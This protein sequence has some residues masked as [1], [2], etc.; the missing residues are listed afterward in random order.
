MQQ[1]RHSNPR[2]SVIASA[3]NR[4][5]FVKTALH[6]SLDQSLPRDE[7]EIVLVKNYLD[8]EID[9][10]AVSN[11]VR[12]LF[13]NEQAIG[14][15]VWRAIEFSAGEI[16]SF[17]DDDDLFT[18]NKLEVVS[19]IMTDEDIGYYHNCVCV[20]GERQGSDESVRSRQ[21]SGTVI[22]KANE[23]SQ[24]TFLELL[25]RGATFNSSS[26]SVRR[27][28]LD[29]WKFLLQGTTT[30]P[31]FSLFFIS[32]LSSKLNFIDKAP[33]TLFRRHPSLS[34]PAG[35]LHERTMAVAS[36]LRKGA[37]TLHLIALAADAEP[38]RSV[39]HYKI[40]ELSVR[41]SLCSGSRSNLPLRRMATG[42]LKAPVTYRPAYRFL[43]VGVAYL[44]SKLP[45]Q[46]KYKFLDSF[47]V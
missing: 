23:N 13:C 12:L 47:V 24:T 27:D 38:Y 5:E 35:G 3:F 18:R 46:I 7:Y 19:R 44:R 14:K 21:V 2:I 8:K 11:N 36:N 32:Q 37:E 9:E 30:G 22:F 41:L 16:I 45:D 15:M 10:Y 26:V 42:L 4:K 43:L 28:I 6:S 33:L 31:G 39:L 1:D 25:D 29:R 34:N 20:F 40:S 17:L